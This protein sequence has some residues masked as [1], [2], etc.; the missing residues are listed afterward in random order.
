[1]K[2]CSET[3]EERIQIE[4]LDSTLSESQLLCTGLG[5]TMH[6]ANGNFKQR[7]VTVLPYIF[8]KI[9]LL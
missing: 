3:K 6:N 5:M 9:L 1:M 7:G 4:T 8:F 2:E